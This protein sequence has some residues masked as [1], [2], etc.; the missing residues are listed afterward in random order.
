M[1]KDTVGRNISVATFFPARDG[2]DLKQ[3]C[4]GSMET[5]KDAGECRYFRKW[6]IEPTHVQDL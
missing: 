6:I 2:A 3:L 4:V 1:L 5:G